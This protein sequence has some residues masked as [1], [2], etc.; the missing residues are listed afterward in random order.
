MH[1]GFTCGQGL[2]WLYEEKLFLLFP[3]LAQR[4]TYLAPVRQSTSSGMW[5]GRVRCAPVVAPSPSVL[6]NRWRSWRLWERKRM[7]MRRMERR[8]SY[9]SSPGL[10]CCRWAQVLKHISLALLHNFN[11]ETNNN[12][13]KN[14]PMCSCRGDWKNAY[15]N[16]RRYSWLWTWQRKIR[17]KRRRRIKESGETGSRKE[18]RWRR[19]SQ[20]WGK[21]WGK[22][23][24]HWGRWRENT[25][26]IHV[27]ARLFYLLF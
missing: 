16:R 17:K 13:K 24:K 10:S 25:R 3:W 6:P 12:N 8:A 23:L 15:K 26:C 11:A 1:C 22:T 7:R 5:M 4:S 14:T 27:S 20:S 18:R 9:S 21:T 19:R 2:I